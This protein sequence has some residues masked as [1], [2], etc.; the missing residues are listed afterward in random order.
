MDNKSWEQSTDREMIHLWQSPE[1]PEWW[2]I[3]HE[4]TGV[5]T[6]GKTRLHALLMLT[7]AL[8]GYY[9][10]DDDLVELSKDVFI[11]D[12]TL[13]EL[14]EELRESDAGESETQSTDD[15]E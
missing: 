7:D 6:Q 12:E 1:A 2:I 4:A 11:P 14:R 5:T 8:S 13:I 15:D 3:H 9:D 10:T